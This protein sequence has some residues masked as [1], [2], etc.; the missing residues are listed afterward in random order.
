LRWTDVNLERGTATLPDTK[1]G[2][3]ERFIGAPTRL[4][5][6]EIPRDGDSPYVFPGREQGKPLV[7]INRVWYAVRHAAKLDD[8]QLH[9][10]RHSFVSVIA[11]IGGSLLLIGK[12]LGHCDSATTAKYAH[13]LDAPIRE[14]ADRAAN[15]LTEWLGKGSGITKPTPVRTA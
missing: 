1:T 15:T 14:A 6:D 5:R 10:L 4:L 11:S 9:D 13:L 2:K 8:V 3:S 7:E 12:L